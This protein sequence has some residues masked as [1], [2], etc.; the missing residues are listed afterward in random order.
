MD[1]T[2]REGRRR[3]AVGD[4][5]AAGAQ[6]RHLTRRYGNPDPTTADIGA[7]PDRA[8]KLRAWQASHGKW[9]IRRA[10]FTQE[11]GHGVPMVVLARGN[12]NT[13]PGGALF[14]A[15]VRKVLDNPHYV[16]AFWGYDEAREFLLSTDHP[17]WAVS[18]AMLLSLI[19]RVTE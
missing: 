13:L 1:A 4:T 16:R 10:V 12:K 8:A 7:G 19:D 18:A 6:G 11:T 2:L 17:L 15:A 3:V 14:F 9:G 5:F